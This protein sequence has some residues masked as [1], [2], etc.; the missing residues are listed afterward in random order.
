MS[1][2]MAK[3]GVEDSPP[4]PQPCRRQSRSDNGYYLTCLATAFDIDT[5]P[6]FFGSSESSMTLSDAM[7][8][9]SKLSNIPR[10]KLGLQDKHVCQKCHV[11]KESLWDVAIGMEQRM[12]NGFCLACARAGH[13]RTTRNCTASGH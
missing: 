10:V 12:L 7:K 6:P 5:W 9:I 3:L 13:P 1:H 11:L 4:E 8:R 2:I